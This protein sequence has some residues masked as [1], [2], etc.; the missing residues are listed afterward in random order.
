MKEI[1]KKGIRGIKIKMKTIT[2][3]K[4]KMNKLQ[5]A[6]LLLISYSFAKH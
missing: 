2:K 1:A 3:V 6:E 5:N 4:R